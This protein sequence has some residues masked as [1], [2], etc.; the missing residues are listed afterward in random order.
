MNKIFKIV[1]NAARGKMMVVNEATSS[2]QT[3]KK[4]AVAVAVIGALTSGIAL[5]DTTDVL[6]KHSDT[7]LSGD[8]YGGGEIISSETAYNKNSI[9]VQLDNVTAQSVNGGPLLKTSSHEP[10]VV[11]GSTQVQ[12]TNSTITGGYI[13]GAATIDGK[14]YKTP[15]NYAASAK[16][17]ESSVE[18]D[19][20]SAESSFVL[21]GGRISNG[22]CSELEVT[23]TKIRLT[24]DTV[25]RSVIGGSFVSGNKS[26]TTEL[27]TDTTDI[28]IGQG[29][30]VK[31][32]V[33][34]GHYSNFYGKTATVT[35]TNITIDGADLSEA[36]VIGGNY[37]DAGGTQKLNSAGQ[38]TTTNITI[39]NSTVAGVYA[40]D[41]MSN[42]S[43]VRKFESTTE[44][45]N[46][47]IENSTIKGHLIGGSYTKGAETDADVMK[48]VFIQ[49][50]D[51]KVE[52]TITTNS[53]DVDADG[54]EKFVENS[55]QGSAIYLT[56]VEAEAVKATK[57]E[58][59]LNATG[60][61]IVSI[62]E[63]DVADTVS[64]T[65]TADSEAND[66]AVGD[67]T[68]AIVVDN[69]IDNATVVMKEGL[70]TD[71]VTGTIENGVAEVQGGGASATMQNVLDLA[72]N[73]T[74]S[75]NRT[76]LNDVRK[77][78]G[79]IRAVDGTHG[80]W[81]RYNGGAFSGDRG[82][83]TDFHTVQFGIDTIP[84]VGAPRFG[85]A[86][87]YTKADGE[88]KHGK[89][90]MDAYSLAFYGTKM[91]DSGLFI[92]VIGRMATAD[93]D[94]TVNVNGQK[95]GV[96]D[97]VA[98]SLS[99]EIGMRFDLTDTFYFEPQGE[100]TYTYVNA[101]TL[102]MGGGDEFKF[103]S[104]DSLIGRVGF[105]AGFKCPNNFG[106]VYVRA[107][108]VH[109]FLGDAAVTGA[110]GQSLPVDGE[111]TWVE[112]G[113]GA[114]FNINK[115][116]YVYADIERTEGAKLEEDWRANVGVRFAF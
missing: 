16:F 13:Q 39:K 91:Y 57:G 68:K 101:D 17:N 61:G 36:I 103:D 90:E 12:I 74:L 30:K 105:A 43:S 104:V 66:A 89:T 106:D 94:V 20:V 18:L 116:T 107:S 40:S 113:L 67:I 98:L 60:K 29:V 95:T 49:L 46:V 2:V 19:G 44:T 52:G 25:V 37:F 85:I 84:E 22:G 58:V 6:L 54:K 96:M 70:Y 97:N 102:N 64:V 92:D 51:A 23:N 34:G 71:A 21:G 10:A 112:F 108:A 53:L 14:G 83:D 82:L 27:V 76:A 11:V 63:L 111:D 78:L 41:Y 55:I 65:L 15:T 100:L 86:F 56:N 77:R 45:A 62:G 42:G 80:V 75:L 69:G 48:E 87:S 5:A 4:A 114:N 93:T 26:L 1:F 73:S 88:M 109:E 9:V 99:G 72:A 79:D 50:K 7:V 38:T 28:Y 59:T 32:K 31:D 47:I 110:N 81:A 33:V 24:G 35:E 3:G 8:V 115:N